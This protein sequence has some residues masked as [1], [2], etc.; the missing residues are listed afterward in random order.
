MYYSGGACWSFPHETL[1]GS[2]TRP[3][4]LRNHPLSPRQHPLCHNIDQQHRKYDYL[5]S[6]YPLTESNGCLIR[7]IAEFS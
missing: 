5:F 3:F 7:I 2:T 4:P 1:S 6:A